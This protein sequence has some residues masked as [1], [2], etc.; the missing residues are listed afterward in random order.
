[1]NNLNI[2]IIRIKNKEKTLLIFDYDGTLAK[3]KPRPNLAKINPAL[4][5]ALENL[6]KWDFLKI[7]I[8]T[9]REIS[10]FKKV[11]GLNTSNMIIF[12]VHGG[13]IEKDNKISSG[14]CDD[15]IIRVL[16]N[17]LNELN[18][19]CVDLKG[20]IIED[21][22]YSVAMHYRIAT[23]LAAEKAA[24]IFNNLVEKYNV[25]NLF[26]IQTGK[27]ILELLPA[28]FTKSNAVN[29]I[30]Q[31]NRGYVPFY[32]GDDVT[33]ISAFHEV[34]K[35]SGYAVGIKP[36]P[37]KSKNLVD[38]EITQDEL[39]KFLINLNYMYGH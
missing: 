27:K 18:T 19:K 2:L 38:F 28:Q 35:F 36:L 34:K 29:T 31:A 8:V 30:V 12:G 33:D 3:I 24:Y 14:L 21:K 13:E 4:R 5:R 37:F 20:I 22:K 39:E 16:R 15:K 6:S 26:K 11:S 23:E 10:D 32:F 7:S 17:F 9:G 25:E 1:M